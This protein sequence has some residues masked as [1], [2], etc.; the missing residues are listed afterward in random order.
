V[1]HGEEVC[2]L[3]YPDIIKELGLSVPA[4]YSKDYKMINRLTQMWTDFAKTGYYK[5]DI[6]CDFTVVYYNN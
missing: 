1:S 2:Y 4:S 5:H 6:L 3:F